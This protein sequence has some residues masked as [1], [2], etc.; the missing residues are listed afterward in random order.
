M[1][2][3]GPQAPRPTHVPLMLPRPR[4]PTQSLEMLTHGHAPPLKRPLQGMLPPTL[5]QTQDPQRQTKKE[6]GQQS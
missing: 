2:S 6:Q 1:Q 3:F 5:L 4:Q